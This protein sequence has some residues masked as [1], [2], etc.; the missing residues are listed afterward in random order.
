MEDNLTKEDEAN[1]Q[2]YWTK[3]RLLLRGQLDDADKVY[4]KKSRSS[5]TTNIQ[6]FQHRGRKR[7]RRGCI[8][9]KSPTPAKTVNIDESRQYHFIFIVLGVEQEIRIPAI[10][11]QNRN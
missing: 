6:L 5:R 4:K 2:V 1:A 10:Q 9:R 3:E 11:A 7:R 8:A